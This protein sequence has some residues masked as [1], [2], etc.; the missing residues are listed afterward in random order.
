MKSGP[1]NYGNVN[2]HGKRERVLG[3]G[4]CVARDLRGDYAAHL[5]VKEMQELPASPDV[6]RGRDHRPASETGEG[7][8]PSTSPAG[9][10][11]P[12]GSISE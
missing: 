2:M 6:G 1:L 10:S 8:S 5:A 9:L 12:A 11:R 7:N 3:C 4:C